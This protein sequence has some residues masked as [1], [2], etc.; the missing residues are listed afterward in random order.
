MTALDAAFGG[1]AKLLG[2]TVDDTRVQIGEAARVT[3]YWQREGEATGAHQVWLRLVDL[4]EINE[5][6]E[7]WSEIAGED[8]APPCLKTS[9]IVWQSD[10]R[11]AVNNTYPANAWKEGEVI[12]DYHEVQFEHG[13]LPG[14]YRLE[15]GLFEP[16]A[17]E[18]LPL[19]S[20]DGEPVEWAEVATFE[21][22]LADAVPEPPVQVRHKLGDDLLI[23]GYDMPDTA[24]E[25][26]PMPV[27]VY[28]RA[29]DD[30]T[31]KL[32]FLDTA[33]QPAEVVDTLPPLQSGEG[34]VFAFYPIAS[35]SQFLWVG[36]EDFEDSE[37]WFVLPTI[38][39]QP[40]PPESLANFDGRAL[41][42]DARQSVDTMQP[43]DYL[44]VL[45]AWEA[46]ARF[47]EDYTVFVQLVGPDGRPHGQS[48]AFPV[49]GTYPTSQWEVGERIDDAY[50]LQLDADAPQG[51]YEIHLGF[52]LLATS[53][54][55]PV[56]GETG[57]EIANRYILGAVNV[58]GR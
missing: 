8:T 1:W 18:G 32:M 9:K 48:D 16:F 20:Q 30:F 57:A 6:I 15:V 56:I 27:K 3:L 23:T 14:T 40:A 25:G 47:E 26:R 53:E 50:R 52:Y 12:P 49:Q 34:I 2:Y 10:D 5:C 37:D 58:V 24:T 7:Y 42:L 46:L 43:G 39:V 41:L 22:A 38:P 11:Y 35:P 28:L 17:A 31:E 19:A 44:D 21:V 4:A 29:L 45:L 13:I 33:H 51:E 55:L 54:R 36:L